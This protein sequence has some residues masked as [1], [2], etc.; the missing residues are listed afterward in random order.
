MART[1]MRRVVESLLGVSAYT[2]PLNSNVISIDDE[3]VIN[4][5]ESVGGNLALMPT[6]RT[7]WYLSDLEVAQ[8]QADA[9]NLQLLGQ[10]YRAMRSDGVITGLLKT[11]T[12]GV[13]RLPKKFYGTHES[14]DVLKARNGSRSTFDDMVPPAELSQFVADGVVL[15][16]AVGELMP[17]EGRD[18]PVFRRLEPEF[19]RYYW[20]TNQWYYNSV[21]GMIPIE[22]GM[23]RWVL[24][25]PGAN[26]SPWT[27]GIWKALGRAFINKEHALS[28]RSN[29]SAKL[30]NPARVVHS[31]LGANEQQRRNAL[32]Q[33]I[34]WGLNTTVELPVGWE[35]SLVE[36]KGTGIEVFQAEIDT[37]DRE[38]SIVVA[39]QVVTVDGGAGFSNADV[40]QSIRSDIVKDDADA[41]AYT[42]NTQILPQF[43]ATRWGIEDI[44]IGAQFEF[45]VSRPK[46]LKDEASSLK[47]VAAAIAQLQPV[48]AGSGFKLDMRELTMRYGI[49]V[50]V[51]EEPIEQK[52]LDAPAQNTNAS[53]SPRRVA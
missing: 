14:V 10:L 32:R 12:S 48:L 41:I 49:P 3:S 4:I 17:V 26:V 25:V 8:H 36:S 5:R 42:I 19:L 18:F 46:D 1:A 38:V 53:A 43:I 31:P 20:V 37:C 52:V 7:R 9:G 27:S 30:A 34:A 15:G 35:M 22:P 40:H 44:D 24:H 6:T 21:A 23:G 16:Y 51:D 13:C 39:G 29:Y 11:R 33:L 45:D 50:V 2:R 47:D 28:H